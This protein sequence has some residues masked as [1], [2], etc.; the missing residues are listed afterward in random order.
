MMLSFAARVRSVLSVLAVSILLLGTEMGH[1][2]VVRAQD[3]VSA[4]QKT[5][6][7]AFTT[8]PSPAQKGSKV[9]D[10]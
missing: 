10:A 7:I 6:A 2:L 8:D 1:S 5:T 3:N 4:T 9:S